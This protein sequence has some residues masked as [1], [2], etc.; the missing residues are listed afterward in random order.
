M[1]RIG[2]CVSSSTIDDVPMT[3]VSLDDFRL[4]GD[5]RRMTMPMLLPVVL[6]T[7]FNDYRQM[8]SRPHCC[9]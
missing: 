5:Q 8:P 2:S 9:G 6:L 1:D 7:D 3:T 4:P